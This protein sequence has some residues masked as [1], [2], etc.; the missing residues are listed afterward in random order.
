VFLDF[1]SETY[2]IL[3]IDSAWFHFLSKGM[4]S[5]ENVI[6]NKSHSIHFMIFIFILPIF[7]KSL[8]F[9]APY[10]RG[11]AIAKSQNVVVLAGSKAGS[12]A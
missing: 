2:L 4:R 8:I 9:L 7:S 11:I 1:S 12:E 6:K 5:E 10:C 3:L